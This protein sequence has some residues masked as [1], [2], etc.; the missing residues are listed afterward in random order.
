M[1]PQG[2]DSYLVAA[3]DLVMVN[4]S[5]MSTVAGLD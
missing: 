5:G 3:L 1:Y 4:I 2:V